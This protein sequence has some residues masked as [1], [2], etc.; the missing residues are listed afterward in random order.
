ML[1]GERSN[2][3]N[4]ERKQFDFLLADFNSLKAEI[5]RRSTLQRIVLF[6]Y[7]GVWS[8]IAREA[9]NAEA[10]ALLVPLHWLVTIWV[11]GILA[12]LFYV[13]EAEAITYLGHRIVTIAQIAGKIL[14]VAPQDLIPS[15]VKCS[16]PLEY[17]KRRHRYN[18]VFM[19]A[20]F[21]VV[22]TLITAKYVF[23]HNTKFQDF[24]ALDT[25]LLLSAI[26]IALC[27]VFI[28]M[29][30]RRHEGPPPADG[31]AKAPEQ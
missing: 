24:Q 31:A 28:L 15:E 14:E 4:A 8:M 6:G 12:L 27:G 7:V 25:D 2:L 16:P 22:P 18:R 3:T 21:F 17:S 13:H 9:P 29:L 10:S 30:L 23:Y 19:W 1:E 26:I 11:T 5:A 20:V